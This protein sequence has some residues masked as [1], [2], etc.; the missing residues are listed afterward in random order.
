[1]LNLWFRNKEGK[2]IYASDEDI[3]NGFALW[4]QVSY[5][6]EYGIPPYLM[7]IYTKIILPLWEE[8]SFLTPDNRQPV[9]R[10]QILERHHKVFGRSLSSYYLR[11]QVLPQLESAGLIMQERSSGDGRQMVVIPLEA[12]F[13]VKLPE[14]KVTI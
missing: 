12:S 7:G 10:M 6:Q 9:T 11:A 14:V 13:E 5:G 3:R 1:M 8:S 2:H 4:E